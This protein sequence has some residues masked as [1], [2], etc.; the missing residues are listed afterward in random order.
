[1]KKIIALALSLTFPFLVPTLSA[2]TIKI[3]EGDAVVSVDVPD[4]WGP[5]NT[6]KGVAVESADKEATVFF[7]VTSAKGTDALLQEECGLVKGP[8]GLDQSVQQIG[9]GLQDVLNELE[10]RLVGRYQ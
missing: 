10:P 9:E 4:S 7:E 8:E 1:M 3:P 5:E 6:E 2:K